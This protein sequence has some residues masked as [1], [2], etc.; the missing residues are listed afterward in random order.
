[1]F[2]LWTW[3][4]NE[5]ENVPDLG[6]FEQIG[7]KN[8]FRAVYK[9]QKKNVERVEEN[10][11]NMGVFSVKYKNKNVEKIQQKKKERHYTKG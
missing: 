3:I 5:K 7:L 9:F 8:H 2:L 4:W 10:E 11:T 6:K 1:M